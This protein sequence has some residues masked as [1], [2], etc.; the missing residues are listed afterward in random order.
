MAS[1]TLQ[2]LILGLSLCVMIISPAQSLTCK[3]QKF[4]G[5]KFANCSDLPVLS[6]YLHWTYDA[7]NSS[8][9]I[10]FTAPPPKSDGWVA[11]AINPTGTGMAGA[12]AFVAVKHSN[13]S[14]SVT[15][16]NITSYSMLM[17][18]KLSFDVWGVSTQ[19]VGG[20]ITIFAT[21]KV[22]AK[23][24]TLNHIWQVGPGVNATNGFLMKHDFAPANL[25]AKGTLN[26][27]TGTETSGAAPVPA[28]APATSSASSPSTGSSNSTGN[29][30]TGSGKNG[31]VSLIGSSNSFGFC[32]VSLLVL[33][34]LLA[35]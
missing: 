19:V 33:V 3:S 22:P 7:S 2:I 12:Q 24:K 17:P 4:S 5:K 15:T 18:A 14:A 8:L 21:A 26:L 13:G 28:P 6:S 32:M 29:S 25:M 1:S 23:A 10:A 31:G 27:S 11:W 16:Y 9:S 30:T 20:N 35:F 34:N